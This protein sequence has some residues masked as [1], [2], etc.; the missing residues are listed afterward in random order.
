MAVKA[1]D[2]LAHHARYSPDRTAMADLHTGRQ[3]SYRQFSARV[4][5]L[6]R[7]L[8]DGLGVGRGDRVGMLAPNTTDHFELQFAC[9]RLG[10]VFLPLN[11]RLTVPELAFIVNDAGP[12]VHIQPHNDQPRR[13][14]LVQ[15]TV[16]AS[17]TGLSVIGGLG[18]FPRE[19]TGNAVFAA[20]ALDGGDQADRGAKQLRPQDIGHQDR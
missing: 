1:Y 14:R 3:F 6:A 12:A 11:W 2:W 13:I 7:Y 5:R 20:T 19:V 8:R 15:N 4:G 9:G 17:T 10:A 16:V 18:G